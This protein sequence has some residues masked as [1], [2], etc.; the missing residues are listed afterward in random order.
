MRKRGLEPLKD[1]SHYHLKVACLPVPPLSLR[2]RVDTI[3]KTAFAKQEIFFETVLLSKFLDPGAGIQRLSQSFCSKFIP[4]IEVARRK[5][6][7]MQVLA[8]LF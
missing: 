8:G 7:F 2:K 3:L 1:Y 4:R 6:S 5:K